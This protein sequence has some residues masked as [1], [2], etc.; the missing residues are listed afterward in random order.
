MSLTADAVQAALRESSGKW[1][2]V[3]LEG[4]TYTVRTKLTI[5]AAVLAQAEDLA[6]LVA[7]LFKDRHDEVMDEWGWEDLKELCDTL[8]G[9]PG[10]SPASSG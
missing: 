1:M 6:G 10:N 9:G 4:E 8:A 3:T 2:Q 7:A 5:R